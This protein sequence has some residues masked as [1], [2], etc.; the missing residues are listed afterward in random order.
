MWMDT[1]ISHRDQRWRQERHTWAYGP[2]LPKTKS[3]FL[4]SGISH[5]SICPHKMSRRIRLSHFQNLIITRRKTA[6]N[7]H[8]ETLSSAG[9]RQELLGRK[10]PM[11]WVSTFLRNT[12]FSYRTESR[13]YSGVFGP[14]EGV[15]YSK[16]RMRTDRNSCKLRWLQRGGSWQEGERRR[17]RKGRCGMNMVK[18]HDRVALSL[19]RTK[20]QWK[21]E[22]PITPI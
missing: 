1:W 9:N 10:D 21:V 14:D 2:S 7:N 12:S 18:G 17:D 19:W 13:A 5:A 4:L 20:R 3:R 15:P 22:R 6:G 16:S 8:T 11:K